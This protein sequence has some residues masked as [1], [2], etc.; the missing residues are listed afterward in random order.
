MPISE[1]RTWKV[2][3]SADEVLRI[4]SDKLSEKKA[5]LLEATPRRIE[6]VIGSEG[7]TRFFGGIFVSKE[8]LPVKI[9]MQISDSAG[10]SEITATIQDNLGFGARTGMVGKYKDYMQSLLD[11]LASALQVDSPPPPPP[12]TS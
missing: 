11:E 6:G 12:P 9:I 3:K 1:T 4:V 8:T 10:M 5:T 7:K 2:N